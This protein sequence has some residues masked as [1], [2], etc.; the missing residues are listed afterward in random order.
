MY[1]ARTSISTQAFTLCSNH[2]SLVF[3]G[4]KGL[5]VKSIV[6]NPRVLHIQARNL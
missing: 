1:L 6:E 3:F 2:S 5:M 4:W